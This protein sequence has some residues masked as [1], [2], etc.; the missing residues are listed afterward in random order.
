MQ[1][2]VPRREKKSQISES[3][4]LLIRFRSSSPMKTQGRSLGP[5]HFL[6]KVLECFDYLSLLFVCLRLP[7]N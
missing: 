1:N 5:T 3:K 2:L 6:W 4:V 7:F